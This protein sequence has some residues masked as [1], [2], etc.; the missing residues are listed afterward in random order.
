MIAYW[1]VL[2]LPSSKRV[3][4][5]FNLASAVETVLSVVCLQHC[6]SLH[7]FLY[8][9]YFPFPVFTIIILLLF[10]PYSN[11]FS[12]SFFLH[13][14]IHFLFSISYCWNAFHKY[15]HFYFCVSIPTTN[16]L[17]NIIHPGCC[18][19]THQW[20]IYSSLFDYFFYLNISCFSKCSSYLSRKV[21]SGHFI[22]ILMF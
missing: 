1:H 17:S 9:L 19:T 4:V 22:C 11:F 20:F 14:L 7:S 13:F 2:S 12:V 15:W 8:L 16:F 10:K 5:H 18:C 6:A 3:I 21:F